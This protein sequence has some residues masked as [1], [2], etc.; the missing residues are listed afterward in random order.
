[1]ILEGLI[2][3]VHTGC[4]IADAQV[5]CSGPAPLIKARSDAEGH[6]R[7]TGLSGGRWAVTVHKSPYTA[8]RR[9]YN[10]TEGLFL[11]IGMEIEAL[12]DEVVTA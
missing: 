12:K 11:H 7:L 3:D 8:Q 1:V 4:P 9:W 5:F 2:Q 6:F 10:F